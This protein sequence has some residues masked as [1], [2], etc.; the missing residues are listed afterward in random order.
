MQR[1]Y[2]EEQWFQACLEEVVE[3]YCIKHIAQKV[4]KIVEIKAR[5]EAKKWRIVEEK[6][7]KKKWMEYLQQLQNKVLVEGMEGFQ[8]MGT[9]YKKVISGDEKG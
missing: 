1:R 6:K 7:K 9:K 2:E 4:K 5:E 3:V 8:I